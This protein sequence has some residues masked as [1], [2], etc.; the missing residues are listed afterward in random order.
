M[1]TWARLDMG[2]ARFFCGSSSVSCGLALTGLHGSGTLLQPP[3]SP[4]P[5]YASV[6][7]LYLRG[8]RVELENVGQISGIIGRHNLGQIMHIMITSFYLC[9]PHWTPIHPKCN[10]SF[11]LSTLLVLTTV[12]TS[13]PKMNFPQ[14]MSISGFYKKLLILGQTLSKN[15]AK[16]YLDRNIKYKALSKRHIIPLHWTRLLQEINFLTS[17]KRLQ[18]SNIMQKIPKMYINDHVTLLPAFLYLH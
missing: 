9:Y 11:C 16:S 10:P 3:R 14:K 17:F 7:L 5:S 2:I 18:L 1:S 15:S 8:F 4:A 12:W 6:R 13:A